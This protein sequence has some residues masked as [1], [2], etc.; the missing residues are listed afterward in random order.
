MGNEFKNNEMKKYLD[1]IWI[2]Q[3][4]CQVGDKRCLSVVERF[5]RTL[6]SLIAK[7]MVAFKY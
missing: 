2:E 7:Y 3:R 1:S 5:N 6:R 4:F